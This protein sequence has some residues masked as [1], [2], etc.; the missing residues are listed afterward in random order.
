[1]ICPPPSPG[2]FTCSTFYCRPS[3]VI[4][5]CS[6]K[7][8]VMG[9]HAV[10]RHPPRVRSRSSQTST[11]APRIEYSGYVLC[12]LYRVPLALVC[13]GVATVLREA[14]FW[15]F[16]QKSK[17]RETRPVCGT[18]STSIYVGETPNKIRNIATLPH[19]SA[20]IKPPRRRH[21]P[22]PYPSGPSTALESRPGT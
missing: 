5:P 19:T 2:T 14:H 21:R 15:R 1:M 9:F 8:G 22:I 16:S 20:T 7:H 3:A 10:S 12:I 11:V 17:A 6:A 18:T 13:F 4:S